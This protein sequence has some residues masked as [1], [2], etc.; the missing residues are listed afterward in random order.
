MAGVVAGEGC[1]LGRRS[2]EAARLGAS[3]TLLEH[4][5]RGAEVRARIEDAAWVEAEPGEV[6][7]VHLRQTGVEVV[8]V[9]EEPARHPLRVGAIPRR[10]GQLD[11]AVHGQRQRMAARLDMDE[12]GQE[13]ARAADPAGG[14]Q[15]HDRA[16]GRLP[17]PYP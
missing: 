4:R 7:A 10:A 11:S 14:D 2:G 17:L 13:L 12:R 6:R 15:R 16:H 3:P 5:R 8:P 1:A 9:S